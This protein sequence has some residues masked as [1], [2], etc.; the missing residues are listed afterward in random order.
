MKTNDLTHG[1]IGKG[2][3]LFAIPLFLGSLFQQLYNTVDMLFVGNVLGKNAAAAVGASSILVTCLIN[4]FTG[5]A[6]G[7]GIVISQ[8]FGA[9]KEQEMKE[10]V[11]IAVLAGIA[12]GLCLTVIGVTCSQAV[13]V[14]LHTPEAI[15]PDAVLYVQIYFLSAVPM[16]L[17]NMCSG[18][19][20]AQGDSRTPFHALAAG[21]IVNVIMDAVFLIVLGWGV[22]GVAV[23]TLFSQSMTAIFL[24]VH[25]LRHKVLT[26]QRLRWDLLGKIISVGVP[27]GIQSMILTLSNVVVQYH[28]NGF[29]ENV[30]AAFAVYFKAENLL[31]LPIIAFGQAMVTFTGQNY[32]AGRYDRIRKGILVCNGISAMV[33]VVLSWSALAAGKWILGA[34]CPDQAVIAEGLRI[35]GVTFPVYFIY[36][37][38]EVTGGV[39]RGIGKSVPSM[40]IVIVNLCLIRILLLEIVDRTVHSVEAVAALYPV[41]WLLA[42]VSFVIYYLHVR[43]EM[44]Q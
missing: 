22:A 41:T 38:F 25:M 18:I 43:K 4:L 6:V 13:L 9:R 31:C 23:A 11:W 16:V 35:I 24:L 12:G 1:S 19:L 30:I 15:I 36:S 26:R 37:L 33:L 3:I 44:L 14:K 10:A 32:G 34:F 27:V 21:G 2:Y 7:A 42:T 17:Y 28:I 40:I 39:V 5:V 8:L 29:G 20:R